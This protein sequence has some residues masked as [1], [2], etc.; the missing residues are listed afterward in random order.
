MPE[1]TKKMVV[2]NPHNID[3]IKE[4]VDFVFCAVNMDKKKFKNRRRLCKSRSSSCIK[5]LSSQ[6]D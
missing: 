5:Q 4:E 6:N 1:W 3:E 2:K